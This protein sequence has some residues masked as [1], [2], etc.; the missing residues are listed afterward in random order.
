MPLSAKIKEI[1]NAQ[2]FKEFYLQDSHYSSCPECGHIAY[3]H[4]NGF[5]EIV[6]LEDLQQLHTH[7]IGLQTRRKFYSII[8]LTA[9]TVTEVIGH[10]K[11][12]FGPQSMYFIPE[13]Q[14]HSIETWSEDLQ[15]I[16][17][18]FDADYFLLCIK[19]Q[20]KLNQFPFFQLDKVP[21][22]DLSDRETQMMQ[23]LFWKLNSEKCQ[24]TTFNDDLL[25]RMFLNIILL[26]AERIYN[27]KAAE[28]PYNLSRKEQLVAQFQLLVNQH[29]LDKKQVNEYAGM[30]HVHPHYLNDVVKEV[31]GFP[32][33]YFIQQ[34]LIQEAKSRLIQTNDT[35]SMIAAALNFIDDSYF[36]RFFKKITGLTPVQYR[37]QHKHQ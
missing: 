36:G 16:L 4:G 35:V 2:E 28:Q 7:H 12:H 15:G 32:A 14:L 5:L 22:I 30:L 19:H 13:N 34:Q 26:E 1:N 33:S 3:S 8:L 27:H 6:T 20:I 17:C 37:K 23:H 18:M 9:G 31:S 11:Y 25:V 29:F 10:Q 21:Y 24:K